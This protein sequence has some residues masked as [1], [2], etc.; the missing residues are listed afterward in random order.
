MTK[1]GTNASD[2]AAPQGD[3]A[4]EFRRSID[5]YDVE[6]TPEAILSGVGSVMPF[7]R[8]GVL[9]QEDV[10]E[11][12]EAGLRRAIQSLEIAPKATMEDSTSSNVPA[13][14]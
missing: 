8:D 4:P 3:G 9:R 11:A 6:M 12:F 10:F 14:K 1:H 2:S 5:Y 7:L 13:S